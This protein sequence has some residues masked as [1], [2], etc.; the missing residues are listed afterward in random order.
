MTF[1]LSETNALSASQVAGC[2]TNQGGGLRFNSNLG[3]TKV[4]TTSGDAAV[5]CGECGTVTTATT[6][7]TTTAPTTSTV[8]TTTTDSGQYQAAS[9]SCDGTSYCTIETKAD[10]EAAAA[11][12]GNPDTTANG[13]DTSTQVRPAVGIV[14][15]LDMC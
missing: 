6:T 5:I 2:S 1:N 9:G 15:A 3:S 4:H 8:A 11:A 7:A 12:L 10:C 14:H 13:L